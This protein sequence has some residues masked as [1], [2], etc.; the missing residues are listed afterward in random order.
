MVAWHEM[1]GMCDPDARP[2]GYGTIGW[3]EGGYRVGWY[4]KRGATD[5]TVPYGTEVSFLRLTRMGGC[6]TAY[7]DLSALG[8][9]AE[10]NLS[11][12]LKALAP[13]LLVIGSKAS[14]LALID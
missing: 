11:Q 6:R 9:S 5:H 12:A 10:S 13:V 7:R 2:V 1:P 14:A 8:L 4:T 3:S